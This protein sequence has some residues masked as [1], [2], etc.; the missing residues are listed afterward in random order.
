MKQKR[1]ELQADLLWQYFSCLTANAT[2]L[3]GLMS[4]LLYVHCN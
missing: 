2:V 1:E 3:T 4:H